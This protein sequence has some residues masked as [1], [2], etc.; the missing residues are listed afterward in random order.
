MPSAKATASTSKAKGKR[1]HEELSSTSGSNSDDTDDEPPAKKTTHGGRHAGA[2][3]YGNAELKKLLDL[4]QKEL[5]LGQ[6]GWKHIHAK[7]ATWADKH[8]YSSQDVKSLEAKFKLVSSVIYLVWY[9][10]N[11]LIHTL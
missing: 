1:K 11:H 10:T 5:P 8:G 7:Y 3:N 9:I 6:N 4:T 2:G